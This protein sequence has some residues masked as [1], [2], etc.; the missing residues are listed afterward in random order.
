[1][2]KD[3]AFICDLDGICMNKNRGYDCVCPK[4]QKPNP[5]E[6]RNV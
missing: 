3:I 5:G 4:G 1:M 2:C 6:I